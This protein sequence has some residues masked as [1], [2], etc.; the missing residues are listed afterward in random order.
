VTAARA[1]RRGKGRASITRGLHRGVLLWSV[2]T[3]QDGQWQRLWVDERAEALALKT[4]LDTG[5]TIDEALRA[6]RG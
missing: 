4:V 1:P 5:A 2:R 6:V 3:Q